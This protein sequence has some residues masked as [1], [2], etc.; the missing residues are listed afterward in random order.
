MENSLNST[1][2]GC[3]STFNVIAD[4][5]IMHGTARSFKPEV[6]EKVRQRVGEV[7]AGV[8]AGQGA[9]ILTEWDGACP[10]SLET[11]TDIDT[12]ID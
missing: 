3:G 7:A 10:S 5:I 9:E 1:E 8:G 6:R 2:C 12:R 4:S 11:S